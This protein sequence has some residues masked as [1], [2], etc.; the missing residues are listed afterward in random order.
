[1]KELWLKIINI[2]I[3]QRRFVDIDNLTWKSLIVLFEESLGIVTNSK[4]M[5]LVFLQHLEPL[6]TIYQARKINKNSI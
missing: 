6:R 5:L 1:M 4:E 3:R 2:F